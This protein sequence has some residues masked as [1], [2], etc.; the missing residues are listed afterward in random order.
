MQVPFRG[1][2]PIWQVLSEQVLYLEALCASPCFNV[3]SPSTLSSDKLFLYTMSYRA[4]ILCSLVSVICWQVGKLLRHVFGANARHAHAP[5]TKKEK[6]ERLLS[7]QH[8]FRRAVSQASAA[9]EG[10]NTL[11]HVLPVLTWSG[12]H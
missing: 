11:R 6:P 8:G 2:F 1:L 10:P 3:N 7:T 12:S 5:S 4:V 9:E